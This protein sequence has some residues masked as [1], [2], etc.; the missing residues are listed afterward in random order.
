[1][2]N[3]PST[4][5]KVPP[6]A[7]SYTPATLDPELRSSINSTLIKDGHVTKIQEHLLHTLHAN[8]TNWPTLVESHAR[9]LLRSGEVTTFPALL[10]KV[11]ED[12]RHDTALAPT[13]SSSS[14]QTN[15]TPVPGGGGS[16]EEN[17][18]SST[19]NGGGAKNNVNVNGN[20]VKPP[21]GQQQATTP[22]L[23]LPQAVIDDALRVTREALEHVCEIE[24][25]S[26]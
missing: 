22:S 7:A 26:L 3:N 4:P 14:K 25:D 17:G 10:R 2:S 8:P 1:M 6:S 15:G 23:A 16:S 19:P 18:S 24:P 12:I 9:D 13:S 11:M 20:G 5:V 21:A